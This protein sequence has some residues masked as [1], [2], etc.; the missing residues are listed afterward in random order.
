MFDLRRAVTALKK[1]GF[2]DEQAVALVST[3]G[4]AMSGDLATKADIV[5]SRAETKSDMAEMRAEFKSEIASKIADLRAD[6]YRQ[7]WLMGLTIVTL[8]VSLTVA[9]IKLI[10]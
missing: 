8:N 9:L 1:A 6:L 10:P 7:L 4:D 5:E 2:D 3:I